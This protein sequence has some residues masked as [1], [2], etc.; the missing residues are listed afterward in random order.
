MKF[1]RN[2]YKIKNPT[3]KEWGLNKA[4]V[5]KTQKHWE[6]IKQ[7]Q[8][9][10]GKW[11]DNLESTI[12]EGKFRKLFGKVIFEHQLAKQFGK[13]WNFLPRDYLLRGQVGS[14]SFNQMKNY[15]FDKPMI[16]K[17]NAY[18]KAAAAKDTAEMLK[19]EGEINSTCLSNCEK[20]CCVKEKKV[21]FFK[22]LFSWF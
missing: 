15:T 22:R 1:V 11:I 9:H 4:Q 21:G 13:N 19:L 7:G 17:V 12:G 20:S 5:A 16:A 2:Y 3:Q 18:K 8:V 6:T 14:Q 10:A